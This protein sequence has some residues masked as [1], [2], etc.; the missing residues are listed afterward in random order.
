[1]MTV[2]FAYLAVSVAS[3]A[4]TYSVSG[5]NIL[6]NGS[7]WVGGGVNAFD[8][9]GTSSKTGWGIGIVR[10]VVDD[11]SACPIA[12]S[13]GVLKTSIGYLHP[14]EDVVKTN[15]AQGMITILCPFGWDTS[16]YIQILGATP[17]AMPWYG[18]FKA[19]LAA[20]ART[21][22]NQ[23]DVWIDV[24][25][26]PYAWDNAGFSE[27]QWS[28]DMNDL[29]SVIRQ[30][31][32]NNIVLIPGQAN[33]GQETVLLHQG[34]FLAGKTNVV[35]TI[36]C[37]NRWTGDSQAGCEDRI[38]AIRAA[39][40]ALLFGEAGPDAWVSDCAHL[41]NAS[42]TQQVPTLAWSWNAGDGSSLVNAGA[43]TAWGKQ[44]FPFLPRYGPIRRT[45]SSAQSDGGLK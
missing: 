12:H 20:V 22:A 18:A 29:Y 1:M 2:I 35:A 37:Y 21:F 4:D 31:G 19:R 7:V 14:L 10:E 42:V 36:H 34:S 11:F 5:T 13:S 8:Q 26:E 41:L 23:P 28:K 24:W 16:S 6:K 39:G 25:N 45:T 40:W 43:A 38:R 32:N 33:G 17:S 3:Q 44:F 27:S 9:F 30:A 15:R